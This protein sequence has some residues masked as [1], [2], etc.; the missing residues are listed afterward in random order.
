MPYWSHRAD[1]HVGDG[2][3][4]KGEQILIPKPMQKEM[5][6]RLHQGHHR[7]MKCIARAQQSMCGG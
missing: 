4:L 6:K 3:L 1:I 2:N 5:F 7:M